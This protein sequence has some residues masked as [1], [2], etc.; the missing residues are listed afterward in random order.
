M[1]YSALATRVTRVARVA[2]KRAYSTFLLA[3]RVTGTSTGCHMN[4]QSNNIINKVHH[5]MNKYHGDGKND[6]KYKNIKLFVFTM[7]YKY[8]N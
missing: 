5:N 6:K 4:N 3:R 8:F 7:I 1:P 2:P